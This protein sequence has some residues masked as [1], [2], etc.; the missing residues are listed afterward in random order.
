MKDRLN[1]KVLSVFFYTIFLFTF[2][3]GARVIFA[4]DDKPTDLFFSIPKAEIKEGEKITIGVK[5]NS[6]KQPINAISGIFS[7]PADLVKVVSMEKEK[8]IFNIWTEE[9]KLTS[10]KISFEGVIVTPGFQNAGGL[11]L[12]VT[13][14]AKH[15]GTVPLTWEEGSVLA[16]DGL[17]TNVLSTLVSTNFKIISPPSPVV[18]SKP[19]IQ[20]EIRPSLP[21]VK[22]LV[23]INMDIKKI[24]RLPVITEY[25][26][27]LDTKNILFISGVGEPDAMTKITFHNFSENSFWK[28]IIDYF[29][30]RGQAPSEMIVKNNKDG[31]FHYVSL[32]GLS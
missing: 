26:H 19:V 28:K 15:K 21:K 24:S 4:A 23:N 2:F 17:G 22:D 7:F 6:T 1:K 31:I 18:I 13:F 9:P 32:P 11:I 25:P 3:C 14:E 12:H 16:N 20:K 30:G 29:Y 27:C 8:S 10:N 5:I